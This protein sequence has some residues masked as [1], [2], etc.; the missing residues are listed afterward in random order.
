M[1]RMLFAVC[2]HCKDSEIGTLR[3]LLLE[4]IPRLLPCHN[5]RL[6]FRLHRTSVARRAQGEPKNAAHAVRWLYYLKDAV[7]RVT[8]PPTPSITFNELQA[9]FALGDGCP[10]NDV[11]VADLLVLV[12]IEA[13]ALKREDD[14][15][16]MCQILADLLPVTAESE[17]LT[18]LTHTPSTSI[19]THAVQT[20]QTVRKSR[21]LPM[22]PLKHY[23]DWGDM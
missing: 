23:K 6:N 16:T 17:L 11:E 9:R 12:A 7:N 18:C 1:W 20:A 5:C 22:R 3:H 13:K 19:T 4:L 2:W 14:Y 15:A 21:G 10:L 8:T